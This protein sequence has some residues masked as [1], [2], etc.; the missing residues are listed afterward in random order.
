MHTH[1]IPPAL[2]F[3]SFVCATPTPPFRATLPPPAH[4]LLAVCMLDPRPM[5]THC[6]PPSHLLPA[7]LAL[8]A[9]CPRARFPPSCTIF[10]PSARALTAIHAHSI[11]ATR[12]PDPPRPATPMIHP[13][14]LL[15]DT[16]ALTCIL[17]PCPCLLPCT[18]PILS[19]P[20]C[21]SVLA[22]LPTLV[23]APILQNLHAC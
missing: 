3:T 1:P 5:C 23:F 16:C 9:C 6:L 18:L 11:P 13:A 14:N 10:P 19:G 7:A 15:S 20:S 22:P 21:R 12:T 4:S 17:L 8:V 2:P